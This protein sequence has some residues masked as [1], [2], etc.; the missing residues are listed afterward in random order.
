M[1]ILEK[2]FLGKGISI[3]RFEVGI[4]LVFFRDSKVGKVGE[5]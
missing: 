2:S 3:V 5:K 4:C 1:S